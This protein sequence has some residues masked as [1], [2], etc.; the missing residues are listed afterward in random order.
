MKI[1]MILAALL[2][3]FAS[4]V[5]RADTEA[6]TSYFVSIGAYFAVPQTDITAIRE[7]G[8]PDEGIPVVFFVAQQ[9]KVAPATI[10]E[11]R[12]KG[13]TWSEITAHYGFGPEIFYVPVEPNI[14]VG[15]PYD[16]AY[17]YYK[18]KPRNEWSS[19]YLQDAEIINLVN[20]KFLSEHFKYPA[21][22]IMKMR[23]ADKRFYTI[24]D[25][26][27]KQK[28][29]EKN[30]DH[31]TGTKKQFRKLSKFIKKI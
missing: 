16:H 9:A 25:E 22:S 13:Q 10:M 4:G 11:M 15:F 1:L 17:G 18:D 2:L 20:L 6:G 29:V 3:S 19:M 31:L 27:E 24:N 7:Q 21:N 8:I 23:Q 5:S 12:L 26:I 30:P 14:E 28:Q